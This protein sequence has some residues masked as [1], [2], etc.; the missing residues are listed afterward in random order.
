L[1]RRQ[2]CIEKTKSSIIAPIMVLLI[3]ILVGLTL[4][5]VG[6][7]RR[8]IRASPRLLSVLAALPVLNAALLAAYVFGEDS[9][10]HDGT[11]RWEAYRSPGGALG[12]M[13]VLSLALMVAGAALLA[14]AA[15]GTRTRLF[16]STALSCGLGAQLLVTPTIIGFS[17]N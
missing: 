6:S 3:N 5:V 2:G 1:S 4:L 9:Y 8:W 7:S 17:T 16:R 15:L 10:R 11:S 14:Y 12:P 13:F